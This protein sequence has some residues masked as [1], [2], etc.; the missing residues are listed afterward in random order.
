MLLLLCNKTRGKTKLEADMETVQMPR[1]KE[2][3]ERKERR[4][5]NNYLVGGKNR[6]YT[7]EENNCQ[8]VFSF[9][10]RRHRI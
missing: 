3:R 6:K 9:F 10:F 1:E 4:E 2:K 5:G 7:M 8:N